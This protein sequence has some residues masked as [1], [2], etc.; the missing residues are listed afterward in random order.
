MT[1]SESCRLMLFGRKRKTAPEDTAHLGRLPMQRAA[2][3]ME[4]LSRFRFFSGEDYRALHGDIGPMD[5]AM[6]FIGYGAD[7]A[8]VAVRPVHAARVLGA[9]RDGP[10]PASKAVN[11]AADEPLEIGIYAS[12][13]SGAFVKGIAAALAAMLCG[14]GHRAVA[15]DETGDI[16]A[17]PRHCIYVAPQDFFF[18]GN[19]PAWMRDD[20]LADACIWCTERAQTNRFWRG[21]HVTLM[22]RSV[23][24]ASLPQVAAFAE[25]MPAACILPLR[26]VCGQGA[27]PPAHPLLDGQSWWSGKDGRPLDLCFFGAASPWRARFLARHAERFSRYETFLYLRNRATGDGNLSDVAGYVA[28]HARLML[29]L[30]RDEFPGFEWHRIVGQGMA[31]GCA[32]ISEPCFSQPGFEAG[33]HYLAE[34]AHRLADLAEW[35]LNDGDGRERAATVARVA[36]AAACDPAVEQARAA[37]IVALLRM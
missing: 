34:E 35:A 4:R 31:N 18:L 29:N 7:E 33:V 14:I 32:V 22:A 19:G 6:H 9:L 3:A 11:E 12:S 37:A 28:R 5:P 2:L 25:V 10:D 23:I 1:I 30:H 20:V 13:H 15:G 21:L 8:R 24:D 36:E 26:A 16:E 27:A 17:R